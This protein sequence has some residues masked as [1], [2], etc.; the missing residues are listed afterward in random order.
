MP[1]S[2]RPCYSLEL[3][4]LPCILTFYIPASH[5]FVLLLG[6][7]FLLSSSVTVLSSFLP[8]DRPFSVPPVRLSFLHHSSGTV[9]V[10]VPLLGLS[11]LRSCSGTALS[12]FLQWDR[13]FSVPPVRP[14][15]LRSY[16]GTVLSPFF[17]WDRSFSVPPV[18]LFFVVQTV[19]PT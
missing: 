10:S 15:F 3:S 19:G 8:W 6:L 5:F 17:Q 2:H 13:P 14:S 4:L 18:G 7:S 12:L 11:F 1:C 16:S 9:L